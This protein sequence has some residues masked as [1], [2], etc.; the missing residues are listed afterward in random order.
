MRQGSAGRGGGG[1]E[2]GGAGQGRVGR[3][4]GLYGLG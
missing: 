2:D 1:V 3:A 4:G